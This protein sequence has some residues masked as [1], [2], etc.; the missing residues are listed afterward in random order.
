[1]KDDKKPAVKPAG[2]KAVGAKGKEEPKKA[3]EKK[4]EEKAAKPE[5]K[6]KEKVADNANTEASTA[7]VSEITPP[8]TTE[9]QVHE[10]E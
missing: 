7:V 8:T 10:D 2:V 9:K 5:E 1:M 3:T 4:E 6:E